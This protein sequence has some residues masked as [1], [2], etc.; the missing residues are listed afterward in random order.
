MPIFALVTILIN[1]LGHGLTF[2][3]PNT[4]SFTGTVTE[5]RQVLVMGLS[6]KVARVQS[7]GF[8]AWVILRMASQSAE[9]DDVVLEKVSKVT[10]GF[11][12]DASNDPVGKVPNG[13]V[14]IGD[15]VRVSI[16]GPHVSKNGVNWDLCEPL[17]SNYCR[18]G[19]LYDVG[20]LSG[21]W[22]IPLSPSNELIHYYQ[23][24][25]SWEFALFWNTEKLNLGDS[26]TPQHHPENPGKVRPGCLALRA[27]DPYSRCW[28]VAHDAAYLPFLAVCPIPRCAQGLQPGGYLCLVER[29]SSR[30]GR[31]GISLDAAGNLLVGNV[32]TR[33]LLL[34][35]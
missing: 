12:G 33:F 1:L 25:P 18:Q 14:G 30:A 6:S 32:D 16:S 11:V 17:Y 35:V 29:A 26:H 5:I 9:L 31:G 4:W 3:P 22:N 34:S 20:P 21:D 8:S 7:D 2:L 13:L 10:N 15:Q 28:I 27:G 19:G 24:N 23:P